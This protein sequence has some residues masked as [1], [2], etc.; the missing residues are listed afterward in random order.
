MKRN[1]EPNAKAILIGN[2]C[3]LSRQR[4]VEPTEGKQLAD[5]LEIPFYETSSDRNININ[6]CFD[7]LV[8]C[9]LEEVEKLNQMKE[10]KGLVLPVSGQRDPSVEACSCILL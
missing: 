4:E 2:K 9:L 5:H 8:D 3:H 1:C 6:E 10:L 7:E